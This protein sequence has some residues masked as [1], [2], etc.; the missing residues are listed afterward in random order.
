MNTTRTESE[1]L[2]IKDERQGRYFFFFLLVFLVSLAFRLTRLGGLS[3]T[4]FEADFA[5]QALAIA[6]GDT[7][8]FGEQAAYVGLTG[9]TLFLFSASNFLARFWV[10]IFSSL[11]AYTPYLFR[12]QIGTWEALIAAAALA[13]SPEMVGLSRIVGSPMMAAVFL[14]LAM[15]LWLNRKPVLAGISLAMGLMGGIGFWIGLVI[16]GLSVLIS[17][18][19]FSSNLTLSKVYSFQIKPFWFRFGV[20]FGL[21][22][23]VV[24]MGFFMAPTGLSGVFGGLVEFIKGF[25]AQP[26]VPIFFIP[27]ALL[28]YSPG[29]VF[30]G[31]WGGIR[32]ALKKNDLDRFLL[33]SAGVGLLFTIIYPA[34]GSPGMI[35]VSLPLWLLTG[36][37][38]V[39]AFEKPGKS[40]LAVAVLAALIFALFAFMFLAMRSLATLTLNQSQQSSYLVALAGGMILVIAFILLVNYGW[41]ETAARTG[42]LLGLGL[43]F[44]V[45]MIS[46]SVNATGIGPN[47]PY[48][49][50]YPDEAVIETRWV[51]VTIDRVMVWNSRRVKPIETIVSGVD[52]PGLRWALRDYQP[53]AFIPFAPP[54]SEP[55][56][57]ITKTGTMPEI[58][59]G[60]QGQSLVWARTVPWR[61]MSTVE[62]LVWLVNRDVFT[63]PEEIIIWI[64]ADLMPGG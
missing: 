63:V 50:W 15:G 52:T 64:R 55:G 40:K 33:T 35:W 49:L 48:E 28:A 16:L 8:I 23:L 29:A 39:E 31:L 32:G 41:S 21:T 38:I 37:V 24:G 25:S 19:L 59:Q 34:A 36:R 54:Q 1:S 45:G 12:K 57:L 61:Q 42:L 30:F 6:K 4:D 43:V 47:I 9:I 17:S 14:L 18:R 58:S 26:R 62:Y 5:L 13:I 22:L 27:L 51:N 11:I 20:S 60:Y 10:A 2:F 3:L 46:T 53:I 56:V 44:L 7:P